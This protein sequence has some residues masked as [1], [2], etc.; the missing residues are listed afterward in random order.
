MISPGKIL[1]NLY[2]KPVSSV[3]RILKTGIKQTREIE[4]GRK[5]MM[6]AAEQLREINYPSGE[7][8]EVYFLTG[9]KYWYQTAF[10]LYSL[11]KVANLNISA[12]IVDDG[13][14]D[15]E[16][17]QKVMNAFP[18]SKIF[19][20]DQILELLDEKLPEEQF[21]VLR[22]RRIEYPHIRKLTDIHILPGT[23][24][25]L[26][27]DSDMLF[28]HKPESLIQWLQNPKG[29]LFMKDV[30]ESYGY[31][32]ELMKEL[33]KST[34]IPDK[35]NVGVA[36]IPSGIID[37]QQLEWWTGQLLEKEGSSYLQEQALTAMIAA[38]ELVCFLDEKSYK[39]LPVIKG[40]QVPEVL[41]H[42][43]ADSKYDYF[44]K[45]WK[46]VLS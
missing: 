40:E 13:S 38:K 20:K 37:W 32:T 8:Y 14:F 3:K 28:F 6:W 19:K 1:Y 22:K 27:L 2:F 25:K 33:C 9:K 11:Q 18:S 41:H 39:V 4:A 17:E 42:Y 36:G 45:G 24:P 23:G 30:K 34:T 10:C 7:G 46:K 43:V 35:L 15:D 12:V 31:N 44:V 29:L 16:L 26:V 21:L 5:E